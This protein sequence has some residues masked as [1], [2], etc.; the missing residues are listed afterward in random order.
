MLSVMAELVKRLESPM[1]IVRVGQGSGAKDFRVPQD[2]LCACSTWF[3]NALK[4]DRFVEGQTRHIRLPEDSV[5][6]F[7]AF[8]AFAYEGRLSF[9]LAN[10]LARGDDFQYALDIW[11]FGEKYMLPHL[12]DA[13]VISACI[14]LNEDNVPFDTLGR[15][16]DLAATETSPFRIIIADYAVHRMSRGGEHIGIAVEQHL[17][18]CSGFLRAFH[19][20]QKASGDLA[21]IEFPRYRTPARAGKQL[22]KTKGDGET[23]REG[24]DKIWTQASKWDPTS[25]VEC[26]GCGLYSTSRFEGLAQCR[27]C[28]KLAS[29]NCDQEQW[30]I[31]CRECE[32]SND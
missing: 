29:C 7:E 31:T 23:W 8:V 21:K 22:F 15:C 28:D 9:T 14:F 4:A 13:A 26:G 16:F 2:V 12:Q 25:S 6:T 30:F 17:G 11:N 24:E 19:S 20:S 27:T 10:T 5:S 3:T 32:S 18:G 1:V